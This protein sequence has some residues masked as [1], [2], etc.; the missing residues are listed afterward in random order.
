MSV[1]AALFRLDGA[2][3]VDPVPDTAA[4]A[5]EMRGKVHWRRGRSW[6]LAASTLIAEP[7]EV[8][9]V[10]I[11]ADVRLDNRPELIASLRLHPGLSDAEVILAAYRRWGRDC[12]RALAGDFAFVIHDARRRTIFCARDHFGV[13]PFYYACSERLFAAATI[14]RFLTALPAIGDGIDEQGIADLLV[15]GYVDGT[16][17]LHRDILRL[18]PG[19]SLTVT[20]AGARIAR[21]WHPEEVA[22]EDCSDAPEAFRTL[23]ADAV[24]RRRSRGEGVGVMLSGG[25]DSSSVAVQASRG[26]AGHGRCMPSLSMTL[27]SAP[28]WNERPFIQAVLD[29]GGFD[30]LFIDTGDHDP[31]AELPA[32]LD[33]QEGPFVA[34]NATLARRIYHRAR[35]VGLT[36]L[37]DGH[38]GDEVVS[39]GLGRLN[40][41]ASRGDWRG[42]WRESAGIAGIYGIG[43]WAVMS[44]YLSHNRY[45]RYARRRLANSGF[46]RKDPIALP[47]TALVEP[48]LAARVGLVERHADRSLRASARHGERDLHV[49]RLAAPQQ[50]Y[51]FEILDRMTAAAGVEGAYPFYDLRLVQFCLS[52]P[53]HHKLHAGQPR[54]VLRQAMRGLL[55]DKVRLR[56]DKYDFAPALADSLLRRRAALVNAIT[57]DRSG[58][59]RFVDMDVARAGLDRLFDQGRSIE[60]ASLFATWRVLM[61]S[62]W[63]DRREGISGGLSDIIQREAAA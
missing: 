17:T 37:L 12:A 15:G 36:R 10:S 44:P 6:T 56:R 63:L 32:L 11:A 29:Q 50:G 4:A 43:R 28:D 13:R 7:D 62:T 8:D 54:Y 34:Y 19:H 27:D 42:L 57:R 20:D 22:V 3:M 61:L 16:A 2:P 23:F 49:E 52:L 38:G 55:P 14:S 25:L 1:F 31:V 35:W 47:P 51:G 53:S 45:V 33:E 41:L 58:L 24:A 60:G 18:P 5:I 30:P 48:G 39:H 21:Y 46:G 40:E 59:G 26:F 9:G